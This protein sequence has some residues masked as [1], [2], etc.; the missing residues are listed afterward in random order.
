MHVEQPSR[1]RLDIT[2]VGPNMPYKVQAYGNVGRMGQSP[3]YR[4]D[5]A[6]DKLR[7]FLVPDFRDKLQLRGH[8]Q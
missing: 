2:I 1:Q 3:D 5:F 8:N 7:L 6:G 4:P